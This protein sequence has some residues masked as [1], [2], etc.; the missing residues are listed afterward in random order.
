MADIY[1][2]WERLVKIV[3]LGRVLE[4]PENNILLRQLPVF[5]D[6]MK[7][8]IKINAQGQDLTLTYSGKIE[9][10]DSMK[11][12]VQLGELGEGTWTAK[13]K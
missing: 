3:V 2:P 7:F 6:A 10:K 8:A 4:V 5:Q 1:E 12:T 13:R 9:S 11:G